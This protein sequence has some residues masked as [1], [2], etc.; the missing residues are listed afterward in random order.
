MKKKTF[1]ILVLISL[2]ALFLNLYKKDAAPP[3]FNADEAAFGYN[4][5][6]IAQ[7]GKDEYGALLPLRLKSYGDYTLP[8]Y[9]Y[10]SVPAIKLFGLSE[11]SS[12]ML[13]TLLAVLFPFAMFALVKELFEKDKPAILAAL[14]SGL[15]WGSLSISRQAHE[16]YLSVFLIT[17]SFYFFV[18]LTKKITPKNITLFLISSLLLLFSY[19]SGRI[20]G[21]LFFILSLFYFWREKAGRKI[22]L[23]LFTVLLLF[24]ITDVI[25][26]PKRVGNLLFFNTPGFSLKIN[27]LRSEG[28]SRL[29]YNKLAVAKKEFLNSYAKYFS[30]QFLFIEGDENPRFGF[31][32]MGPVTALE[33]VFLFIGLYYLFK[34]KERYRYL[35]LALLLISPV[36]AALSWAGVSLTRSLFFL[37]PVLIIVSYGMWQLYL[38]VPKKYSL[39][40]LVFLIL[41]ELSL[42]F[43]TWDFYLNHYPKRSLVQRAW[44]TG[45]REL[46]AYVKENYDKYDRFYITRKN[47]QPYIFLLFYMKYPPEKYQQQARLS[48]PDEYG[49]GQVEQFDKFTFSTSRI[50]KKNE[51]YVIIGYP[52]DFNGLDIDRSKI[53]KIT[54]GTQEIFWIYEVR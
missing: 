28:G 33:Y 32:D 30:P 48:S 38:S 25:Y 24:S 5:Y 34:K 1:F 45:N 44:E 10:L 19:Q 31:K 52:D 11:T 39:F 8:L 37:I 40:L 9:S 46:A 42:L 41:A 47:G 49:F 53:K 14:V 29:V 21:L 2:A 43:Y 17:L 3:S 36:P 18:R 23:L 51:K 26:Q 54:I 7:T 6:S 27:E 12:R 50:D 4:A 13:N 16:A 35:L 15:S 20:F 22:V